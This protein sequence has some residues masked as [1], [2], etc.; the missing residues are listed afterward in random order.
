MK[1]KPKKCLLFQPE[2]EFL[3]RIVGK[4]QISLSSK[5]METVANWPTSS[6]SKDVER[7]LGFANYH[8]TFVKDFA[9]IA[10]PLYQLTGKNKFRWG[11]EEQRSFDQLCQALTQPPTMALP[12]L[13]DPFILDTDASD[14]AIGAVLSQVQEGVEKVIAYSSF[15]LTPEQRKYCTTRKELLSIVRFTRQFKYYLLGKPF[16]VRTNHSSL[17]WLLQ[18]KDPQGQLARWMEKLSQYH[19]IVQHRAGS[20]H[21]NAD[22]LS[23]LPDFLTPCPAYIAGIKPESLPCGGCGYCRRADQQWGEFAEN[24]DEATNLASKGTAAT[25]ESP[26]TVGEDLATETQRGNHILVAQIYPVAPLAKTKRG[27]ELRLDPSEKGDL[28]S[29]SDPEVEHPVWEEIGQDEDTRPEIAIGVKDGEP[30]FLVDQVAPAQEATA[31]TPSCWGFS[32]SELQAEQEGDP[33]LRVLRQFTKDKEEP[34]EGEL[35]LSSPAAKFYWLN[36]DL[37]LLKGGVLFK[38]R[39]DTKDLE[40]VVPASLQERVIQWHHDLPSAARQGVARTKA[41]LKEKFFGYRLTR[42]V[43]RYVLTCEV[44]NRNKKNQRYGRVPLTEYHAGAPMERVHID[45]IVPLPRTAQGNEH[46]LMMVDQFTKWVECV[47][48]PSQKAEVTTKAAMDNFFA[49]F[50]CP[51]QLFSDQGRNFESKLFEALCETLQIHKARTTPYRPAS[52]GQ[53]E[54][55]NRTLMDA[56]ICF[57][58]K[59]QNRWDEQVQQI[60]GAIRSSVNRTTGFTPN[61]LML[62]RE[63]NT[64]GHLMFPLPGQRAADE[65]DYAFC[66]VKNLQE[67][68]TVAREHLKT[69][70]R[71]MKRDYDLKVL[72]RAY[73]KGD[74]VYLLDTAVGKGKCRKLCSPWKGLGIIVRKLSASLYQIKLRNSVFVTNHDRLKPCR[75]RKI[76]AWIQKYGST[77]EVSEDS[78]SV[79]EGVY[80]MCRKPWSGRFMIQCDY[81]LE[82]YHGSCVNVTASD[83]LDMAKYKCKA[84]L[85]VGILA[86][87]GERLRRSELYSPAHV[88]VEKL[89]LCAASE[90]EKERC[91]LRM[92]DLA[93]EKGAQGWLKGA[94]RA[95]NTF[96]LRNLAWIRREVAHIAGPSQKRRA[97]EPTD[98]SSGRMDIRLK[99]NPD[100][101][102]MLV[103]CWQRSPS[104]SSSAIREDRWSRSSGRSRSP[105]R[106]RKRTRSPQRSPERPPRRSSRKSLH[107]SSRQSSPTPERSPRVAGPATSWRRTTCT[108]TT[109]GRLSS[110]SQR[111]EMVRTVHLELEPQPSLI[112]STGQSDRGSRRRKFRQKGRFQ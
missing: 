38:Q 56:I 63:V 112:A 29:N 57:L 107:S 103:R 2:V 86:E 44:C 95:I 67:A 73:S 89:W 91:F 106:S 15:S 69:S 70:L 24:V 60:A 47:P 23:R 101:P 50:G 83:A 14:V 85:N 55:Y 27:D 58:K 66:L 111:E 54:R 61:M 20:K 93:R 30:Y 6:R 68:H 96:Q 33:D 81:C 94:A 26:Q 46:C 45:F 76:P 42:D 79:D 25:T 36:R 59:A 90:V 71:R 43:E 102:R 13:S 21:G 82:W 9:E 10:Q 17:T 72:L 3:G 8:R 64:P 92:R 12:N 87:V 104:P 51:L 11:L 74:L 35:F 28:I 37:F 5:D 77:P 109:T 53:V 41:R 80:C 16:T 65:A 105:R 108:S 100:F 31:E 84:C 75:D 49:R 22:A 18:F 78:E 62:G 110:S 48:L 7:F 52:N 97:Q 19:L 34:E 4:D 39:V 32:Y 1:L 40:L 99:D 88:F 98:F